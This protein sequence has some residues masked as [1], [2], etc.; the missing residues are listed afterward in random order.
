MFSSVY[1]SVYARKTANNRPFTSGLLCF[2]TFSGTVDS[3]GFK[4]TPVFQRSQNRKSS[5]NNEN[6]GV[7][8]CFSG[9]SCCF[10]G[11]WIRANLRKR[12]FSC[13]HQAINARKIVCTRR[14]FSRFL[15]FLE[16][17]IQENACFQAFAVR[18]T[19]G[20]IVCIP[21]YARRFSVVFWHF[22]G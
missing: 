17:W 13:V 18:F 16:R 7:R 11:R 6:C 5:E 3:R 9:V 22:L 12:V 21:T 1:R 19:H 4:K 2:L 14:F 15:V 8:H 10:L 20:N